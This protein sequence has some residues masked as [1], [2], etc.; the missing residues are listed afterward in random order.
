ML[1][2]NLLIFL[3]TIFLILIFY[4]E[5]PQETHGFCIKDN[6]QLYK[7]NYLSKDGRIVDFDRNSNT[8]SEG[9]GYMLLRSFCVDDRDTFDL[10][11]GWTKNN[12]QRKDYL[13]SWLWG[14][15]TRM[16]YTVLDSNSASD[17]DIDIAYALLLAYKK[18]GSKKYIEEARL[19]INSIWEH[20]TKVINGYRVLMP[21]VI[22]TN[23]DIIEINPSYF[24]P[25]AFKLF[26][27]YDKAHDWSE[28]VDSSYYYLAQVMEKT[29]TG[30]PPDWF[31]IENNQIV[32]EKSPRGDFSYDAVRVF[33]RIFLD[34]KINK[35]Q[36]ALPLLSKI[37]F[38]MNK[39]TESKELHVNYSAD[40]KVENND[41]FVGG[42]SVLLPIIKMYDNKMSEEI[43]KK[44]LLPTF[45]DKQYWRS[46]KG[47][48]D[49]N[50]IW[51]GCYLNEKFN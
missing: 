50:L 46:T 16:D 25:Y 23:S 8:T 3:I 45:K 11:Y 12:L 48:Y 6:Y 28:L 17:A 42:I 15:N 5:S 39:W 40:G 18:W 10:T 7:E 13:F 43:C 51:F 20:E 34:Y 1:K 9:Q 14:E 49:K 37:H 22:Q 38:F 19:I 33:P 27:Q 4:L 26:E 44:E 29:S 24:A 30:L 31:L 36:R 35:E 32:L 21:G 2:T 47:Y 41:H